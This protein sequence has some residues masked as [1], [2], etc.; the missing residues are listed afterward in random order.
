[1]ADNRELKWQS[2]SHFLAVCA[3]AIRRVLIDYAREH[4][5]VKRGGSRLRVTLDEDVAI[6]PRKDI[7]FVGIEEALVKL[8]AQDDRQSQVV[9]MR[10]FGGMT[11]AEVADVMQV[12]KR[13]IEKDWTFARAWLH[14]ELGEN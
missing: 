6:F 14:R 7:D 8:A 1:L 3:R 5:S 2:H 9:E 12:S 10:F 11:V 13:S 4:G